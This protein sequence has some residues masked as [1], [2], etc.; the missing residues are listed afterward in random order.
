MTLPAVGGGITAFHLA[1]DAGFG[2]LAF[3]D[4]ARLATHRVEPSAV[5][6]PAFGHLSGQA[7]H[8]GFHVRL[9]MRNALAAHQ[10]AAQRAPLKD[11][12]M[13][14]GIWNGYWFPG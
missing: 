13:I 2:D 4:N 3:L 5:S 11:W 12:F 8:F 1:E 9:K 6:L 7:T 14:P 10:T